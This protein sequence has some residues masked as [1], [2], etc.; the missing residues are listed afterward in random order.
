MSAWTL[1]LDAALGLGTSVLFAYVG[2]LTLRRDA[3]DDDGR[4]A[5]QMFALWW[6]GLAVFSVLGAL[7]DIMAMTGID[8]L[9]PYLF[10]SRLGIVPLAALLWGI[11]YY[12]SYIYTGNARLFWPITLAHAALL[13][14]L[15]VLTLSL[16][17]TGIR[18]DTWDVR[19]DYATD[20]SPFVTGALLTAILLPAVVGAVAYGTLYWKTDDPAARYRIRMVSG[21]FLV[22]FGSA[23]VAS[24][25]Q[26]TGAPWWPPVSHLI[27]LVA[28]F[29][30]LAAYRPPRGVRER[31]E[32]DDVMPLLGGSSL[33]TGR[34]RVADPGGSR[35]RTWN[36]APVSFARSRSAIGLFSFFA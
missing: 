25:T 36:Y 23:G 34:R 2:Q 28:T 35:R 29:M 18:V 8:A 24:I 15:A 1:A 3:H 20:P 11:V 10:L 7:T 14:W 17:A 22:W 6:F 4:R 30:I 26:L 21:A 33:V 5:I 9:A 31:L 27:A 16:E 32:R 12:L 19:L 13:G